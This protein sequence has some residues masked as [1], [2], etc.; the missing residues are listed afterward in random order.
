[1]KFDVHSE[2]GVRNSECGM[3]GR[4]SIRIRSFA[5]RRLLHPPLPGD[6]VFEQH[7]S[8]S[9]LEAHFHVPP[10]DRYTPPFIVDPPDFTDRFHSSSAVRILVGT[11]HSWLPCRIEFHVH[12]L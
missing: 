12:P 8:L 10:M 11:D 2:C 5:S 4:A 3:D 6:Q 9:T 7:H 1:M